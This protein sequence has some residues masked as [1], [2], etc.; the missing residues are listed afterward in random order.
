MY[1]PVKIKCSNLEGE[2]RDLNLISILSAGRY[3][4][5]GTGG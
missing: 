4:T 2:E 1:L 5:Q 3:E